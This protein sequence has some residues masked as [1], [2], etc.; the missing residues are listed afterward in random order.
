M[1]LIMLSLVIYSS[2]S[3]QSWCFFLTNIQHSRKTV[4]KENKAFNTECGHGVQIA[5]VHTTTK[6]TFNRNLESDVTFRISRPANVT[7]CSKNQVSLRTKQHVLV[8]E[9]KQQPGDV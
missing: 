2:H 6:L 4:A 3:L 1:L 9:K 5:S 8:F 7:T